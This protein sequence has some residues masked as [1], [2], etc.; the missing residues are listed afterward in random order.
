MTLRAIGGLVALNA[1]LAVVGLAL[2]WAL[3]AIA[4]WSDAVRLAGVGYL[5]G[6]AAFGTIWTQLLVLG[7]PFGG[8]AIVVTLLGGGI[9][10]CVAGAILGRA[11]PEGVRDGR[12]PPALDLLT[13]AAGIALIG[14]LLEA[15][16]RA[17]RLQG[18]QAYDAWAFWVPKG[19]AIFFFG[20]LDEQVFTTLPGPTYPPLVPI[21]D[22]AAFHAM[23]GV[24]T[25]TLHLQ[26]WFLLVGAVAAIAGC[27]HGRAAAWLVWP[28]LVLVL[29]LPRFGERLLTPQADV[30]VDVLFVVGALLLVAWLAEQQTWQL[31]AAA[32]LLA[33]G[34]LTKR[35]GL[36]FAAAALGVALV[37]SLAW[38]TPHRARLLLA[39]LV[40]VAVAVPWRLWY[41]S[42]SIGGEAPSDAGVGGSL[43]RM[44]DS[45]R[46]SFDVLFDP[47]LWSIAPVLAGVALVA[48][49]LWGD[50][51]VAALVGAV[52]GVVFLGGAWVTYSFRDIP[53]TAVESV[54]PI[55]RYTGAIVL[56]GVVSMPLLL[57]SVWQGRGRGP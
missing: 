9:A 43:E 18:L 53:I 46:L 49:V 47:G 40:V 14:L 30:L 39:S 4:R 28:S 35:E 3:G 55:V 11:P 22:A 10:A 42:R 52:L 2:L 34:T 5:V 26:Y 12:A 33:G 56:L 16:F 54:N 6:V 37:A 36:L 41:R 23:G 45:L 31:V 8:W 25:V 19:K 48:A 51:R 15:L 1:G 27:L 7:V 24:D 50:R 21:L 44:L 13:T 29:V 17:A 38:R 32:T 57:D 20:G